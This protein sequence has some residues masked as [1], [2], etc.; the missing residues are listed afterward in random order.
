MDMFTYKSALQ[1]ASFRDSYENL[2]CPLVALFFLILS[3][4]IFGSFLLL[5][6]YSLV[7]VCEL[8]TA[9]ASLVEKQGL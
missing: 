3:F 1:T 6:G 5:A 7:A 2:M 9:S 4:V 8:V